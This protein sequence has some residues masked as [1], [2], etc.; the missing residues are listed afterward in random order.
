VV[1][2]VLVCHLQETSHVLVVLVQNQATH[3]L[4]R[5]EAL[6]VHL[7]AVQQVFHW[8]TQLVE[9]KQEVLLETR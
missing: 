5:L 3:Y 9:Q 6:L 7:L 2:V 4:E 1:D 8:V